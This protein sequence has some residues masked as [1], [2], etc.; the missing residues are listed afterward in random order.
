MSANAP[1]AGTQATVDWPR[2]VKEAL[3]WTAGR[4]PRRVWR[5][6]RGGH[7]PGAQMA[8][9][10]VNDAILWV[11]S[12]EI[13]WSSQDFLSYIIKK[14]ILYQ[15]DR[16]SRKKE[17]KDSM[18]EYYIENNPEYWEFST[19]RNI[20][21][22][23]GISPKDMMQE[24]RKIY[25]EEAKK[26]A[27]NILRDDNDALRVFNAMLDGS[28]EPRNIAADLGMTSDYVSN[29]KRRIARKLED[30]MAPLMDF[31]KSDLPSNAA[32]P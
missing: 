21:H 32:E 15:M 28:F 22:K 13:Q 23:N 20:H 24:E 5:G 27:V 1:P 25:Y 2:V 11:I 19:E 16:I 30:K 12:K 17:N 10:F 9:D 29:T 18:L 4:L 6:E 14:H 31:F 26:C 8:E 3:L 7:L